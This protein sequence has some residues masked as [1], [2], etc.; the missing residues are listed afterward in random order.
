MQPAVSTLTSTLGANFSARMAILSTSSSRMLKSAMVRYVT[1]GARQTFHHQVRDL[2]PRTCLSP[3]STCPTKLCRCHPSTL[4]SSNDVHQGMCRSKPGHTHQLLHNLHSCAAITHGEQ[5][6]QGTPPD[7]HIRVLQV[8]KDGGLQGTPA[9]HTVKS[10]VTSLSTAAFS[11]TGMVW[12]T[13]VQLPQPQPSSS[14]LPD[15][16]CSRMLSNTSG[17]KARRVRFS[18][19][20]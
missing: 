9:V 17:T 18:N 2:A 12:R 8:C 5:Q 6:V 16:W 7:G 3:S 1:C 19:A 10:E 13:S 11:H 14:S 15:T 20:R 4:L